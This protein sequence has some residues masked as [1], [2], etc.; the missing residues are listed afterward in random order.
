MIA[1]FLQVPREWHGAFS[2]LVCDAVSLKLHAHL[3]FLHN[4]G[5][6]LDHGNT[7]NKSSPIIKCV[8]VA[9]HLYDEMSQFTLKN[10]FVFE[11]VNTLMKR[12]SRAAIFP[13]RTLHQPCAPLGHEL[14]P[15]SVSIT[16]FRILFCSVQMI[17]YLKHKVIVAPQLNSRR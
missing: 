16:G 4:D 2:R 8:V 9:D 6:A 11:N 13:G 7:L 5:Q 12:D 3:R 1:H 14:Q 10:L 15:L 17:A